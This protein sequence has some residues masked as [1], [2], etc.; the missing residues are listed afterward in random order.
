MRSGYS[1]VVGSGRRGSPLNG[2]TW[3]LDQSRT[4][5]PVNEI[6]DLTNTIGS[7][8]IEPAYNRAG[9]MT[10]MP[11]PLVPIQ[12]GTDDTGGNDP[13]RSDRVRLNCRLDLQTNTKP[14]TEP[15]GRV[16]NCG[17]QIPSA[18]SNSGLKTSMRATGEPAAI[19]ASVASSMRRAV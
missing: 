8:W 13:D 3:S 6:T 5:K 9:N 14:Y 15:K 2:T 17:A 16:R 1:F 10:T 7:T 11:Q 12:S 18:N 19:E 4:A